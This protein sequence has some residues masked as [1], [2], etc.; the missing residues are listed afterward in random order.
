[1]LKSAFV[2][3]LIAPLTFTSADA[4]AERWSITV[5]GPASDVRHVAL[6]EAVDFWNRELPAAGAKLSLG[7]ITT[8]SRT[9]PDAE[10]QRLSDEVLSG[11]RVGR[12]PREL[13][14]VDGDLLIV[15][16]TTDL[17]SVGIPRPAGHRGL[18][19]LRRADAPP[20]SLPNVARNVV[21][22]EIG[23]VLGLRHS[24]DPS[25]LMC[26]RPAPCRP[27]VFQS[28]ALK[29]FPLTDAEKRELSGRFR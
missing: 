12:V 8:C 15:L 4:A 27:A 10:L 13:D 1:L 23:H 21:A 9:V 2:V 25:T 19:I 14:G 17:V 5:C 29:F 26:G 11:G 18:V 28:D 24:A 22:H 7:P 3:A 6:T 20:L 16:S